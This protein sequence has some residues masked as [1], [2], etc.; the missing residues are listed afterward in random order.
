MEALNSSWARV[1]IYAFSGLVLIWGLYHAGERAYE[2][3]I[4]PDPDLA[5]M[6][7]S[8][9]RQ[10]AYEKISLREISS[11][12]LFG[13]KPIKAVAPQQ[14][15]APKTRLKLVLLGVIGT[16]NDDEGARAIIAERGKLSRSY[17]VGEKI[18]GTDAKVDSIKPREV[19]L[20]R[21]GRLE[22]LEMNVPVL[23]FKKQKKMP[24]AR[25]ISADKDEN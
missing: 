20:E 19:L 21:G 11:A 18:R 3:M 17:A 23:D 6:L 2:Y 15:Q 16:D 12:Y 10:G 14:K 5:T 4:V 9:S 8:G 13:R 1:L 7:K 22:K 25:F 24:T